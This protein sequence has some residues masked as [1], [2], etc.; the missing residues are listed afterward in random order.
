MSDFE[1]QA[2]LSV[3]P[4]PKRLSSDE[5]RELAEAP[6]HIYFVY[7][8]GLVKI[9]YSANWPAR[10]DSVCQGCPDHAE[11]ILV[12]PGDRQMERGYHALFHEY[13]HRGE[14]FR[15]EGKMREFLVRFASPESVDALVLAEEDYASLPTPE[16]RQ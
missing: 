3:A 4:P 13:S 5:I 14:W 9:G 6:S 1:A 16:V 11:L 10:V 7:S 12:M 15:C 2:E 8:A